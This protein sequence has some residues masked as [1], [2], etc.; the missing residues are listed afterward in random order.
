MSFNLKNPVQSG[1]QGQELVTDL[2]Q[3]H[4]M[5]SKVSLGEQSENRHPRTSYFFWTPVFLLPANQ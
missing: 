3:E 2:R 1:Q 4:M 5:Y